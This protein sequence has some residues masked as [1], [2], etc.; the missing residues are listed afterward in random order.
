MIDRYPRLAK[1]L[2]HDCLVEA[3]IFRKWMSNIGHRPALA[4]IAHL[5]LE[6]EQ[7]LG[8]GVV[9]T[10]SFEIALNQGA[11]AASLGLSLVHLNKSLRRLRTG[12]LIEMKGRRI[13]ILDREKLAGAVSFRSRMF[14]F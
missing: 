14:A 13:A 9:E 1:T 4:R 8:G 6:Y 12:K 7:R 2:W 3:A 11:L 10:N 5:L